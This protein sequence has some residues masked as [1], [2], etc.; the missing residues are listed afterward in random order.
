[1]AQEINQRTMGGE[2]INAVMKGH[3]PDQT[4]VGLKTAGVKK[5]KPGT[6]KRFEK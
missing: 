1:L 4:A 6:A 2:K 3:I 5:G